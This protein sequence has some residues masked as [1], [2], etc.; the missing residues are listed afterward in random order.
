MLRSALVYLAC[1]LP[2]AA[3]YSLILYLSGR[4]ITLGDA[5]MGGVTNALYAAI[6]GLPVLLLV[7]RGLHGRWG[8]FR[9]TLTALVAIIAYAASWTALVSWSVFR[10]APADA[11]ANYMRWGLWWQFTTGLLLGG[12]VAGVCIL[13]HNAQ[14][15]RE[16]QARAA[17][18]E[19]LRTRAELAALRAQL[20]PHFLFNTL[21]SIAAVLRSDPRAAEEALEQLGAML[22]YALGVQRDD[23]EEVSLAEELEF[24][25]A[26][27]AIEQLRLGERLQS[28]ESIDPEALECGILAFTLQPL[29]EN[30]VRHGIASKA[31]A[32]VVRITA[33]VTDRLRIE[34][35]DDGVGASQQL[36][37]E[38]SRGVGI[39][40]VRQRLRARYGSA[41][42]LK[43]E[44]APGR[45]FRASI[46]LPVTPPVA[47]MPAAALQL[48]A[49]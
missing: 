18:A 39:R 6:L 41:A 11:W 34:V 8:R 9:L 2:F 33:A 16:E 28:E 31:D 29:V 25:R 37:E 40:S 21:H 14:R 20:Q 30:A 19:A 42:S 46:T 13:L 23:R 27:I 15:L 7:R 12:A 36:V 24:A 35:T 1:W 17:E 26:Y 44:T 45:G 22:R 48:S 38:G 47:R 4:P 10:F 3:C 43:I 49:P 5:L 32:G